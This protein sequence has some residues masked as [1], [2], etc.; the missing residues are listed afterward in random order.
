[1]FASSLENAISQLQEN[2]EGRREMSLSAKGLNDDQCKLLCDALRG[3]TT[4]LVLDLQSNR[5]TAAGAKHIAC[6]LRS[7]TTLTELNLEANRL[8]E[9]GGEELCEALL[10]NDTIRS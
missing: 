2:E 4:L 1:M 5:V 7:N 3:N 9:A 8:G 10:D 6:M